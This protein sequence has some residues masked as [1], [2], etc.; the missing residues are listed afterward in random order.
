MVLELPRD[1]AYP[2]KLFSFAVTNH[3]KTHHVIHIFHVSS[4]KPFK[5]VQMQRKP[6]CTIA[7]R[8]DI[9]ISSR[10]CMFIRPVRA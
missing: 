4:I 1:A 5:H 9:S 3:N 7:S 10:V 8:M 6:K 2:S